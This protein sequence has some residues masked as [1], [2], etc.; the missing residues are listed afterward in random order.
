[1][2]FLIEYDRSRGKLIRLTR[3]EDDQSNNASKARLQ[4]EISL[5]QTG[6]ELEVVLLEAASEDELQRTH[7]RYF[8]TVTE[9]TKSK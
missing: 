9:L 4:R 3:F 8:E 1:V 5:A 7:R 6:I 2:L